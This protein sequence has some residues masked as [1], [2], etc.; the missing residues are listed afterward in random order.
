MIPVEK[1]PPHVDLNNY[2]HFVKQRSNLWDEIQK[3]CVVSASS[4][5]NALGQRSLKEQ[6]MAMMWVPLLMAL[7]FKSM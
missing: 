2:E 4:A 7:K 3:R 1:M 5:F 6:K